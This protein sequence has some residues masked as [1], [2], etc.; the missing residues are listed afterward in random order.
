M[1]EIAIVMVIIGV[2]TG[3]GISLMKVLT[4]RKARNAS[5]EY[6]K[7]I[8]TE[9]ISFAENN[10]R[11]PLADSDGDG[12]ENSGQT[13]GTFPFLSLQSQPVDPYTRVLTYEV[14]SNLTNNRAATCSALRT[15]LSGQSPE[16]V[17]ADGSAAAFS[18]AAILVSAGRMDADNNGNVFDD[19]NSGAFLGNN[20]NGNPNYLRH[21][22]LDGT[23]DDL[24]VYIGGN[25]LFGSLCEYLNLAVNN[26]SGAAVYVH[27]ATTGSD[28]GTIAGSNSGLYTILSGTRIEVRSA[29]A[30]G[31]SVVSPSTPQTPVILAGQG[32]TI[33]IP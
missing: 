8:R 24:T 21:P 25:E 30:G 7:Q 5:I 16:V 23:F 12:L 2:L 14:N 17:D 9:L 18:V 32:A 22:P 10:G 31:G 11:L 26:A 28:L 3:G 15:G 20:A 4:E 6:L 13:T 1:L 19:I 33:N 27:N 29:A